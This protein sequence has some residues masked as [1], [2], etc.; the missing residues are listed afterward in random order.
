M[1]AGLA[2]ILGL[3]TGLAALAGATMNFNFMLAGTASTNPVLFVLAILLILAWKV[4]G[5]IGL[6]RWVL[7]A[8]GTPWSPGAIVQP[9]GVAQDRDGPAAP[10]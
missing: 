1:A 5:R 2:L 8:V 4:A 3:F 9:Q 7:P 6:D 10:A